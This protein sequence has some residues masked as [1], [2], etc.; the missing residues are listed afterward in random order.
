MYRPFQLLLLALLTCLHAGCFD[1]R[2]A[3]GLTCGPSR[4]CPVGQRCEVTT[5]TCVP[6][7]LPTPV[8]LRFAAEPQSA[9]ALVEIQAVTVELLDATG[10]VVPLSGAPIAL[11][12]DPG[13]YGTALTG[14]ATVATRDGVARFEGLAF[15]RPGRQVSLVARVKSLAARGQSFDVTPTRP[16]VSAIT[17]PDSAEGCTPIGYQLTQAQRLPVDLLVE[18]DPDGLAGPAGFQRARQAASAPGEA[19]V[20]GVPGSPTGRASHFS[21]SSSSDV[22][23]DAEVTLRFTP[24][25]SGVVGGPVTSAPI[26][27]KNG[28]RWAREDVPVPGLAVMRVADFD[29][30]GWPDVLTGAG[31]TLTVHYGNDGGTLDAQ[32][33]FT[34][35]DLATGDFNADGTLDLAVATEGGGVRMLYQQRSSAPVP[36]RPPFGG[37]ARVAQVVAADLDRDGLVDLVVVDG[38]D[39][40]VSFYRNTLAAGFALWGTPATVGATGRVVV[41][42]G[43]NQEATG[44]VLGRAAG[45]LA[46][47]DLHDGILG[48]PSTIPELASTALAVAD[49]D[50]D[51]FDDLATFGPDG[52]RI[53]TRF[54]ELL[55]PFSQIQGNV[56]AL[57]DVDRDA[58][59]DVVVRTA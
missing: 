32:V 33:G 13:R 11:T 46:V 51:G 50:H 2:I 12:L 15:D 56:L 23:D 25:V 38:E 41:S 44:I 18:V 39:G 31:S 10:Q 16:A 6:A 28:L 4:E 47:I 30:D 22:P 54:G 14:V 57:A 29:A 36:A 58:R 8:Q 26:R 55:G 37:P 59:P 1:P 35:R 7:D 27:V 24:S 17:A 43:P 42:R 53:R 45:P 34:I 19:G 5:E 3:E 9:E 49:L 48:A 52:L 20:Q 40:A 21:W